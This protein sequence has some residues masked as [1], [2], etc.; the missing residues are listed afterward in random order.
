MARQRLEDTINLMRCALID[1]DLE[2]IRNLIDVME[3]QIRHV[4]REIDMVTHKV[5]ADMS[6]IRVTLDRMITDDTDES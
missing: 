6:L 5:Q 1:H 3:G 2:M 4:R